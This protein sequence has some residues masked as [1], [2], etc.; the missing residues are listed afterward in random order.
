MSE[1]RQRPRLAVA[2]PGVTI[3]HISET[4]LNFKEWAQ[5][6]LDADERIS[7][8]ENWSYEARVDVDKANNKV[9]LNILRTSHITIPGAA[10]Y[11]AR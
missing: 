7:D 2:L 6:T 5:V 11:A 10:H 9:E 4:Y 3:D 8:K 1:L